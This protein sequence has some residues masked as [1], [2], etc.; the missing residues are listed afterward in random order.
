MGARLKFGLVA[1]VAALGLLVFQPGPISHH[2]AGNGVVAVDSQVS[3][4]KHVL[5]APM[6]ASAVSCA[7]GYICG[8]PCTMNAS[9]GYYYSIPQ[10]V[11]LN[12]VNNTNLNPTDKI[13]SIHNNTSHQWR[14]WRFNS[15][16]HGCGGDNAVVYANTKG[17]MSSNWY[18]QGCLTRI[19]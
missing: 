15:T 5:P 12:A 8:F 19:S 14:V 11:G 6:P 2:T 13:L 1:L 9:C 18:Q 7:S 17:N 16:G 4:T 3:W 10:T